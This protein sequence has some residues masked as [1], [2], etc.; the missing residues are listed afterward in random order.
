[1]KPRCSSFLRDCNIRGT[2]IASRFCNQLP[3]YIAWKPDLGSIATDAFLH[4]WGKEYGFAFPPFS[5]ISR[6][7]RKNLKEKIYH[8]IRVTPAWQIQHWY[9]Q[10]LKT[11]VQHWYEQLLKTSVQPR[12][13]LPK[14]KNLL[15]NPQGKNHPLVETKSLRLAVWKVSD[16]VCKWKEFQAML[17]SLVYT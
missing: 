11:S 2:N 4:P 12:F 6:A 15:T 3:W 7:L 5:L 1:M 10:L 14:V 9:E 13:R 16:K 8:L 17:P